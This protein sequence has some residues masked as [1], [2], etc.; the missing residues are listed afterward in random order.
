MYKHKDLGYAS[1]RKYK[2]Y[3]YLNQSE[4]KDPISALA[5]CTGHGPGS[6][7]F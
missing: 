2:S 1:K 5:R 7:D 4:I 6:N 3:Y